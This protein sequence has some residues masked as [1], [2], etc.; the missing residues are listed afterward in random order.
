MSSTCVYL[1]K[2]KLEKGKHKMTIVKPLNYNL[3]IN[4]DDLKIQ[5]RKLIVM[6]KLEE[7]IVGLKQ[8]DHPL[9]GLF[10]L[11]ET[12]QKQLV[13]MGYSSEQ[14]YGSKLNKT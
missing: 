7:D 6:M 12:I 5:K 14:V 2:H 9:N 10:N 8:E 1:S 4:P 3:E 13:S 11:I